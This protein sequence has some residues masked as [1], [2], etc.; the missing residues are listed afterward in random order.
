MGLSIVVKNISERGLRRNV[1]KNRYRLTLVSKW[2]G[3][4]F[5]KS[6][7]LDLIVDI[8]QKKPALR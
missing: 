8:G 6:L 2:R 5:S 1:D 4:Y 7:R 3:V